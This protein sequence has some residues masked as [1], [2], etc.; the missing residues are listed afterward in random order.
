MCKLTN[1][2]WPLALAGLLFTTG[3]EEGQVTQSDVEDAREDVREQAED[4]QEVADEA[5]ERIAEKRDE[6]A[7]V[8]A[9]EKQRVADEQAKLNEEKAEAADVT[10]KYRTQEARDEYE[11]Q[12]RARLDTAK[13]RI[14]NFKNTG[15]ALEGD[16]AKAHQTRVDGLNELYNAADKQLDALEAAEDDVWSV[17]QEAVDKAMKQLDAELAKFDAVGANDAVVPADEPLLPAATP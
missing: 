2:L 13:I 9:E 5:Q 7:A 3:C 14:D 6:L 11:K 8:T 4:T 12:Q 16:A 10:N 15:D 1:L 17:N